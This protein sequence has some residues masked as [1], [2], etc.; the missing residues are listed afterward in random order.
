MTHTPPHSV[1]LL[2]K[3]EDATDDM[4]EYCKDTPEHDMLLQILTAVDYTF[5]DIGRRKEAGA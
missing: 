2:R 4:M 3:W 5:R 1:V